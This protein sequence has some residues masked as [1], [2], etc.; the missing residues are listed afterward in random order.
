MP[1]AD[2]A[3]AEIKNLEDTGVNL[4]PDEIVWL[5][6]LAIEVENPTGRVDFAAAGEPVRVGKHVMWPF[7]VSSAAWWARMAG[8]AFTTRDGAR[9]ALAF[10][11]CNG[12]QPDV[13]A[14]ILT[15][16]DARKAVNDWTLRAG[17]TAAEREAAILRCVPSIGDPHVLKSKNEKPVDPHGHEQMIAELVAGTGLP[18]DYWLTQL[19][20]H[21]ARCLSAV[22]KQAA[23]G[24]G[25]DVSEDSKRE[26]RDAMHRFDLAAKTIRDAHRAAKEAS[27]GPR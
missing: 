22:Y 17:I 26:Y 7:T 10:C 14:D 1:L 13:F 9:N 19:Q 11:L 25:A 5:N 18:A 3:R 6:E 4:T 8:T 23:I 2:L 12:R 16:D 15:T 20:S 24:A 21:A 27:N